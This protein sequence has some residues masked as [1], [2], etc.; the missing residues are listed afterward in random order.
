MLTYEEYPAVTD[1]PNETTVSETLY[2]KAQGETTPC[3]NEEFGSLPEENCDTATRNTRN[4]G[5]Q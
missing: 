4:Y 3:S 2:E 1:G 5:G